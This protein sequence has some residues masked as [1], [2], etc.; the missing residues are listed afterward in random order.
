MSNIPLVDVLAIE[1]SD[2]ILGKQLNEMIR[3]QIGAEVSF[4]A[5]ANMMTTVV[6]IGELHAMF[7]SI[8]RD[9]IALHHDVGN[10]AI[11]SLILMFDA[12]QPP[13][14]V[15]VVVTR[16]GVVAEVSR[17]NTKEVPRFW[18]Q[19]TIDGCN[20]VILQRGVCLGC[21]SEYDPYENPL[22][23]QIA[24]HFGLDRPSVITEVKH[25]CKLLQHNRED[26]P[27]TLNC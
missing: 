16:D 4:F 12:I 3:E 1:S 22:I 5:T 13:E 19:C 11:E 23:Q 24:R 18:H 10:A 20:G 9:I 26:D 7:A 6:D 17:S 14:T 2:T 27:S 15:L 25:T 21:G 8:P